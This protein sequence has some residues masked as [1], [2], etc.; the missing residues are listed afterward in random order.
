MGCVCIA[1]DNEY[2]IREAF[3]VTCQ[4]DEVIL[5]TSARYGRMRAGRCVGGEY[6]S[7]GVT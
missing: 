6:E 5:V 3:N 1:D 2:C 7:S 4:K